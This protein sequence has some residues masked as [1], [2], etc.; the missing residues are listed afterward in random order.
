MKKTAL[1]TGTLGQDGAY[2]CKL[3]L[4]KDYKVYGLIKRYT[5]PNFPFPK[6]LPIS[7]LSIFHSYGL[8]I[9]T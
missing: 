1:V 9:L 3:L 4:E 2:L 8:K 5:N 6:G 7:N